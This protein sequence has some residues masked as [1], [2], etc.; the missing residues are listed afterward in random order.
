MPGDNTPYWEN[1]YPGHRTKFVLCTPVLLWENCTCSHWPSLLRRVKETE[2][3]GTSSERELLFLCKLAE[4]S[5]SVLRVAKFKKKEKLTIMKVSHK[6]TSTF[7]YL[8][9]I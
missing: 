8:T 5:T 4:E 9:G 3:Q 6:I 7:V 1:Q 2:S